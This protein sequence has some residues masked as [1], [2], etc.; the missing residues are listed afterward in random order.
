MTELIRIHTTAATE[1]EA[2]TIA[3]TL[4]EQRIVACVQIHGPVTS[5]Y[6]W[7][8]K[9]EESREWA[10][11]MKTTADAFAAAQAAIK[12]IHSYDVPQIVATR[13]FDAS[14]NYARWVAESVEVP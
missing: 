4:L 7:D 10:C 13:I 6:W 1:E 14:D 5:H 2:T 12:S 8:G 3:R 11:T 9:L